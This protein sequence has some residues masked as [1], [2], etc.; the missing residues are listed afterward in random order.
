MVKGVL[1][2]VRTEKVINLHMY[3]NLWEWKK[4]FIIY[5]MALAILQPSTSSHMNMSAQRYY[6]YIRVLF[7]KTL[8]TLEY[9][10]IYNYISGLELDV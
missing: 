9:V 10:I 4:L 7:N 1:C 2:S 8:H 3:K 6:I 5:I